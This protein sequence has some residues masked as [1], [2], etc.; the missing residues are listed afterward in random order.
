MADV[1]KPL[2]ILDGDSKVFWDGCMENKLFIQHCPDCEKYVFYPRALCPH[3]M[4][5]AMEWQEVSGK[6][7]VYS[8]SIVYQAT[9]AFAQDTPFVMALIDLD[10]GVRILSHI[11]HCSLDEV[12]CDMPVKVVF[13]EQDGMK[14]PK[15]QPVPLH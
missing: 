9:P 12:E 5:D 2:P 4:G 13:E 15:F 14:L 6:G 1:K 7:K 11:I 10:E 3:C 8:Y